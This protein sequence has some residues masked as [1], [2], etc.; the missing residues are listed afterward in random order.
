M[1]R[2]VIRIVAWSVGAL[3]VLVLGG[4]VIGIATFDPERWKPRIVDAIKQATGRDIVLK[5]HIGLA[6]SLRPTIK[7]EDIVLSN[8]P[9]FS[10]PDMATVQ[11][12]DLQLALLSL[13]S[14]RIEI[15]RLTV[16]HP[17]IL[18]E[19]NAQGQPN[20]VFTPK[21]PP[22][23][24]TAA[25][26]P[27]E[28]NKPTP[29]AIEVQD[30]RLDN[31][32]FA[33]RDGKTG[34][35]SA[36]AVKQ[37]AT[38]AVSANAPL[39]LTATF[40]HEGMDVDLT[41]DTGPLSRLTDQTATG[42]FPVKL[43]LQTA[44]AKITLEG[45]VAKP[46][47]GQGLD[48]VL[49]ADVPDL[50]PFAPAAKHDLPPLH[51][52]VLT[53]RL[54]DGGK[55]PT[56]SIAVQDLKLT[57]SAGDLAGNLILTPGTPPSLSGTLKAERI[58]ADQL[59]Q[60]HPAPDT[61][62]KTSGAP[63]APAT[64]AKS[65]RLFPD[66]P[67][68]FGDL[69]MLNTDLHL[70]IA[71]LRLGG[72]DY[73]AIAARALLR[74]GVLKLDPAMADL[75]QG[76]VA[77]TLTVDAGQKAPP[78]RLT[79]HAP[80]IALQPL[81]AALGEPNYASGN[82]EVLADLHGAGESPHAIAASL[83]GSVGL[84][85]AGGTIDVKR[86][87]GA[88]TGIIEKL[89]PKILGAGADALRCFAVRLDLNKGIG[90]F[91]ALALSSGLVTMD[92]SGTINIAD[93]TLALSVRSHALV[94]NTAITMP[95]QVSGPIAAPRTKIDELGLARSNAGALSGSIGSLLG[96]DKLLSGAEKLLGADKLPGGGSADV[97]P[98]A[99]A[100]A[101]GQ[102]G[103]AP[104]AVPPATPSTPAPQTEPQPKLP[105]AGKLLQQLFR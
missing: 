36:L 89:N 34:Q 51:S 69:Q 104:E 32:S 66:R 67:I 75:P 78:V 45:T 70:T 80:G 26:A 100:L 21:Q 85:V 29:L 103:P 58:D 19:T 12:L 31:G 61:P 77:I 15:D 48:L 63:P 87:G 6:L 99:L 95:M 47:V 96:G 65:S 20:W 62:P 72:A 83:D 22:M 50:A 57:S 56:S 49:T 81:L 55:G 1:A 52:M 60:R 79:A 82:L 2:R 73:K 53:A 24:A 38:K 3:F 35:I 8:P 59:L 30:V 14:R 71:T 98:G 33:Y 9:G 4:I 7:V 37:F 42:P 5:G 68:P 88:A 11:R 40:V 28:N 18:F 44:S 102:A 76:H 101:R 91:R 46:L 105:N 93:E 64:V 10:R 41:A 39:H 74:D 90:T 13:L 23:P 27:A 25:G 84:A 54:A 43:T 86:I 16:M 94:G 92:G 17:D 97:C